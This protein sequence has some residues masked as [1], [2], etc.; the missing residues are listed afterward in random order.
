[1]LS[2]RPALPADAGTI[3]A[4]IHQ[5]ALYEKAPEKVVATEADLVK[6]M[7]GPAPLVR[8]LLADW[9]GRS[10]GFALFFHTYSTWEG[11][12]CLYLEDLFVD[13]EFRGKGIGKALLRRL[14]RIA[15]AE[16]CSRFQ[17]AVLDWNQP[18]IDFYQS[19]GAELMPEWVTCRVE[20]AAI[21]R[22]A[23]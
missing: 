17:W 10:A 20:G 3:L 1:M 14:A 15:V 23:D 18:A 22:L 7:S 2:L 13:P 8:V 21:G 19:L 5:L 11:K 6:V 16:D 9:D 12:R 4:F